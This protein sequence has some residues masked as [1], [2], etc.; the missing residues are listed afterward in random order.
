MRV[1]CSD[2]FSQRLWPAGVT[3]WAAHHS[4]FTEADVMSFWEGPDGKE[5]YKKTKVKN[6]SEIILDFTCILIKRKINAMQKYLEARFWRLRVMFAYAC[7][8]VVARG[9]R[10]LTEV[11]RV[12]CN[13]LVSIYKFCLFLSQPD[14]NCECKCLENV[15]LHILSRR[16]AADCNTALFYWHNFRVETNTRYN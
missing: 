10:L 4:L 7:K 1:D 6:R 15:Q 2:T 14:E 16:Y 13:I 9:F 8:K 12:C 5:M 3:V 11:K